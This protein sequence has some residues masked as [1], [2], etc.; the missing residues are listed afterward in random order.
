MKR[1]RATNLKNPKD[2]VKVAIDILLEYRKEDNDLYFVL[3]AY[4]GGMGYAKRNKKNPSDYA[5]KVSDRAVI[6]CRL[7]EGV[8][9]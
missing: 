6:L 1:L 7:Y 8:T 4:N 9:N 5:L 2:C 3:M